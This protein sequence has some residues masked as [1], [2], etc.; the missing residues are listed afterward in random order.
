[1]SGHSAE[2]VGSSRSAAGSFIVLAGIDGAGKSSC[3]PALT[4][5]LRESGLDVTLVTSRGADL[6]GQ[7]PF[8]AEHLDRLQAVVWE[9]GADG[10]QDLFGHRHYLHLLAAWYQ[11][12][13]AFVV[14]PAL[15]AG[16][17]VVC[18]GWI[19]KLLA[20]SARRS[21]ISPT[22]LAE[23]FSALTKPDLVIMLDVPPEVSARRKSHISPS[24]AGHHDGWA[25]D[26]RATF[27]DY[28]KAIRAK[29]LEQSGPAYRFEVVDGDQHLDDVV[30]ACEKLVASTGAVS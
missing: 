5:R 14:R 29:L 17:T 30:T 3:S 20:R 27:V 19:Q 26:P 12:V 4:E 24:E 22:F 8:V 6:S 21:E 13:D 15:Q 28:Q 2:S 25:G 18:D 9:K 1:M 7:H 23:C 16:T 10:H 11:A